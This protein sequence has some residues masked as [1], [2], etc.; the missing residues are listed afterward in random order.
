[1]LHAN[2]AG[3]LEEPAMGSHGLSRVVGPSGVV[4]AEAGCDSEG[5]I[6]SEIELQDA[7]A[8]YAS[9]SL[10]PSYSLRQWWADGMQAVER[11]NPPEGDDWLPPEG[12]AA[13]RSLGDRLLAGADDQGAESTVSDGAGIDRKKLFVHNLSFETT[14][15]ELEEVLQGYGSVV[16]VF[17]PLG[18]DG[19]PRGFGFATFENAEEAEAAIEGGSDVWDSVRCVCLG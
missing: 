19:R 2:A 14:A 10:L 8:L 3:N 11:V 7:K 1:M 13:P 17:L 6:T 18:R 9:K 16:D 4:L 5:L 15:E 12:V